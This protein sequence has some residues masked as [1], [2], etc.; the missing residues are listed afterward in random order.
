MAKRLLY[1]LLLVPLIIASLVT[2]THSQGAG[3]AAS[4][5]R[6]AFA[7]LGAP[8]NGSVRYCTD[9][10]ATSPCTGSGTGAMASRVNGAWNCSGGGGGVPAGSTNDVQ[11]NGG[12]VFAASLFTDNGTTGAYN[13]SGGLN[14]GASPTVGICNVSSGILGINDG[15]TTCAN[16]RDLQ[17][18]SLLGTTTNNAG[19]AGAVGETITSAIAVGSATSLTTATAKNVT[20]VSLTAG[21]WQVSGNCNFAAA[22]ATV[23]GA[24]GGISTTTATLPVDGTEVYSGVQV[25]VLSENDSVTLPPKRISLSGTTSTFLICRATFS[26]GTVTAF[27][28]ITAWRMR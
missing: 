25:T 7:S 3:T 2:P 11:K 18:R 12:G 6:Q 20:S 9:C 26:A 4:I 14:V 23:T 10:A 15:S 16:S 27:G 1:L 24:A 8:T 28:S 5:Y 21:D 22:S 17:L 19:A 13:G